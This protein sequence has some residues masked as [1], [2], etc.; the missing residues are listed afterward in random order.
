[1]T[2][3]A[4]LLG[5]QLLTCGAEPLP[6]VEWLTWEEHRRR[7]RFAWEGMT[8]LL[9]GAAILGTLLGRMA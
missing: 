6:A 9:V 2:A 3:V 1:V 4:V 8:R 7:R 5:L